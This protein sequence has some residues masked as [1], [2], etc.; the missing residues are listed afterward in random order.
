LAVAT[1]N[2]GAHTGSAFTANAAASN[3]AMT[4]TGSAVNAEP[5]CAPALIVATANDV[6]VPRLNE[7]APVTVKV[8]RSVSVKETV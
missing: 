8:V 6:S 4:I 3:V 5:V 2:A 1:I 7:F